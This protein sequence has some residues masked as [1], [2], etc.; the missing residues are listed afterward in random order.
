MIR[1]GVDAMGGDLGLDATIAASLNIVKDFKDVEIVLYGKEEEI[2]PRLTSTEHIE[3]V[4][5]PKVLDMGEHDPVKAIRKD[6]FEA[7][8]CVLMNDAKA[9]KN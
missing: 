4:N 5:C 9:K 6:R 2:R 1:I 3:I 7:S 8:L